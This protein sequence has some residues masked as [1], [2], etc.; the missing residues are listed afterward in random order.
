MGRPRKRFLPNDAAGSGMNSDLP[1]GQNSI[2]VNSATLG[3]DPAS[4][5]VPL[6][7]TSQHIEMNFPEYPSEIRI[8]E[9]TVNLFDPINEPHRPEPGP[10]NLHLP[11]KSCS[12]ACLATLYL[13]LDDIQRNKAST[14]EEGVQ[15]LRNMTQKA[16]E[17]VQCPVCPRRY[18]SLL[19]NTSLL[20]TLMF[21]MA[22]AYRDIIETVDKTGS[23][24]IEDAEDASAS[25]SSDDFTSHS[26]FSG[27][28]VPVFGSGEPSVS[29]KIKAKSVLR[30]EL[31]G[32]LSQ[33]YTFLSLL[34]IF[35]SR[36]TQWHAS[37]PCPDFPTMYIHGPEKRPL[38][39]TSS[40]EARRIVRL[41]EL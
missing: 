36:Q 34:D 33:H 15:Q 24:F 11:E 23:G 12:C 8:D 2:K 39:I 30:Q 26:S 37:P 14:Y 19:Q 7:T 4:A 3:P 21:S 16:V 10:F 9:T 40:K 20:C 5:L 41:L 25:S 1:T 17:V 18:M 6:S 27:N 13:L 35:E 31:F 29:W 28:D 32:M 38:C 22:Q